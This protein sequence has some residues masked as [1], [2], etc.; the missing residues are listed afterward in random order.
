MGKDKNFEYLGQTFQLQLIN[1]IIVDKVFGSSII[2]VMEVTYFENK[3]FKIIVQMI[4]EYH[5]KYNKI[6]SFDTL[7]QIIKSELAQELVCKIAIDT[8]TQIKDV[9][10]DNATFVQDKTL[11]FCKQQELKKVMVK[12]QKIIDGGEFENYDQVESLVRKALQVGEIERGQTDV[13]DNLDEVLDADFRHPIPTGIKGIDKLLKG[14]LARGELGLILAPTGT[15]KAQPISE[16]VLTPNGWVKMGELKLGDEVIGSD[17]KPQYVIGVYPQGERPIYR[18]DFTDGTHVNCDGEHLWGIIDQDDNIKVVTTLEVKTNLDNGGFNQKYRIPTVKPIEFT[19]RGVLIE[20]YILGLLLGDE[21]LLEKN[22]LLLNLEDELTIPRAFDTLVENGVKNIKISE[23]KNHITPYLEQYGLTEKKFIPDDY[24]YNG[25]G[26]RIELLRGLMDGS[27][28]VD[29]NGNCCFRTNSSQLVSGLRELIL[30]L[31]G[32]CEL[33]YNEDGE[34]NRYEL[35]ITSTNRILPFN[36][37]SEIEKWNNS[38][39]K[40]T[41]KFIKAI[42]YSHNEDAVCIK[43]S[44]PDELYVTRDYVLTHNTTILTKF[45]NHAYNMG[46]NVLQIFFEDNPKIIQRKHFT[47][48]TKV[49]PDELSERK[50][51]VLNSVKS[52]QGSLKNRL[53]L[54][55][56]PSDTLTPSAIKTQI[57]KLIAEG[58]KIDMICLDYIDCILPERIENEWKGEGSVI[59]AFEAMCSELDI[60]VWSAVQGNRQSI[61]SDVVTNDQMGGSIKKAQVGHVII[62]I[63]KSLQQKEHK[64][65]TLALTKS[66]I[67][68]DGVVFENCK[69]DNE[70]LEI[71]TESST[72][73][74]GHEE[75]KERRDKEHIKE[76][77]DRRKQRESNNQ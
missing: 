63:A 46:F 41:P 47:C 1:Q 31:G 29:K 72:T 44:N 76:L 21:T 37:K 55:K 40:E 73:L 11:K 10:T 69:F 13:F 74:L 58:V 9:T 19:K 30:S 42:E 68:T 70:M 20:P 43:V 45:A 53:I 64:L 51:Y 49:S 28:F 26:I 71:D 34:G 7:E 3:Y 61:S 35:S 16:P 48:W 17:G 14:G 54:K 27:G 18:V 4:K 15:G 52:L 57:R 25:L 5:T 67:G 6:P 22:I 50:E 77:L 33:V 12:S 8:L 62:S 39:R 36:L 38:N 24:L 60:V 66:R 2:D 56:L 32:A 65:A 59:R 75:E 23:L